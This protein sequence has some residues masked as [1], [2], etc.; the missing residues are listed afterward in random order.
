[1]SAFE[2][3]VARSIVAATDVRVLDMVDRRGRPLPAFDPGAHID[4][5][6]PNG[7]VRQYSLCSDPA[8]LDSYQI[9]V[10]RDPGSRGGSLA[11]RGLAV[12][13]SIRISAPRNHFP[14]FEGA[15]NH[16]L[17]A[18]GIG[19]TPMLCMAKFLARSNAAFELHYCTRSLDRTAF[20]ESLQHPS[21]APWSTVHFDDGAAG[22]KLDLDRVLEEATHG[23]HLYV[24]GPAGFME[25]VLG[26]ARR[27]GWGEDRLHREYFAAPASTQPMPTGE[28]RVKVVSTGAVV[29]VMA[30]Q[31][32]AE[33][34]KQSGIELPVSCEQG[35][36][37]TCVTRIL[38]G[39]P[40]HRDFFLTDTEHAAGNIFTP[41]C[42]RAK[43]QLLVLDL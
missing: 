2:V 24:C 11:V 19:I 35:I 5:H 4:V 27:A 13:D 28:F 33:A 9:G 31:S 26:S 30:D 42:S 18:G 20:L 37:G 8:R 3:T 7:L 22:Q 12:G 41:C 16:L 17:L 29:P 36:C 32:V 40:D 23:T 34:L 10:L 38:E 25:W 15:S 39:V 14:L 43:T 6:L 1:M 21:L